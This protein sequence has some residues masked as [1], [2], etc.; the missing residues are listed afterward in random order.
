[1]KPALQSFQNPIKTHKKES[2]RPTSLMNV[3]IKISTKYWQ[4]EFNNTLKRSHTMTKSV[5]FQGYNTCKYNAA[6]K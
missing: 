6:Y 4:T 2:Y 3:D 5:S 1:M